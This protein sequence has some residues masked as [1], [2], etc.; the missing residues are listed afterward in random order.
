[1]LELLSGQLFELRDLG[2]ELHKFVLDLA[3]CFADDFLVHVLR[4]GREVALGE[5]LR[6]RGSFDDLVT[7]LQR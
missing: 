1:M 4:D 2:E 6:G 5:A 7:Q 3:V